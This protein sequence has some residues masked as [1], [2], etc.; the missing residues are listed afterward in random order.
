MEEKEDLLTEGEGVIL[1][2]EGEKPVHAR[3]TG[4]KK[5]LGNFGVVDLGKAIGK[6]EGTVVSIGGSEYAVLRPS[7]RDLLPTWTRPTQIVTPKD[8]QYMIYLAGI[9]PGDTVLEAGTG[10]GLL[11]AFLANAVGEG[12][13]VVSYDRRREHQE[14]AEQMLARGSLRHRVTLKIKDINPGFDEQG[15]DA[16]ILDVPE[17]WAALA[18][19]VR[20]VHPGGRIVTYTPTYNQLERTVRA[21]REA[22]LADILSVELLE[23]PLHVGEGGTRPSFEMLGHTGFLTGSRKIRA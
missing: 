17:P 20:A 18:S 14:V 9:S 15:A 11:T 6:P 4:G 10:S 12:G 8:A 3:L 16:V 1:Y 7:L 2:R 21:M 5:I 19:A 13:R 22:G 23:R